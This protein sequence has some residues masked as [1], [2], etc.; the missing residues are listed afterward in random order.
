MAGTQPK[1]KIVIA[2]AVHM[3]VLHAPPKGLEHQTHKI[4]FSFTLL[5]TV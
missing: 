1:K 4:F 5:Y 2:E 3:G